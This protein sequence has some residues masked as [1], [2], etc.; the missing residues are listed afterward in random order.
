MPTRN[1]NGSSKQHVKS[2][3]P[4]ISED[5]YKLRVCQDDPEGQ[6]ANGRGFGH[7]CRRRGQE[8][9]ELQSHSGK[10]RSS[11]LEAPDIE[12]KEADAPAYRLNCYLTTHRRSTHSWV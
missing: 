1:Y 12:G 6:M 5:V 9:E 8:R 3:K 11:C 7:A 4:E 10:P 2:T